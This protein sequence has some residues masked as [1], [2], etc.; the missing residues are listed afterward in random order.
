MVEDVAFGYPSGTG[1]KEVDILIIQPVVELCPRCRTVGI[2]CVAQV[3]PEPPQQVKPFQVQPETPQQVK[4]F[5]VQP[6][7]PQQV[8]PFQVQPETPQQVKPLHWAHG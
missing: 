3:Q 8:K 1:S 7:T 5:Q 4:P 6:E 2:S